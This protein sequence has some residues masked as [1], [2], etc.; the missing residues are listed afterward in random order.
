MSLRYGHTL[1]KKV[2]ILGEEQ[3]QRGLC[4]KAGGKEKRELGFLRLGRSMLIWGWKR[5]MDGTNKEISVYDAAVN[6]VG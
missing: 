3:E 1:G 5:K 4:W 2:K 6:A